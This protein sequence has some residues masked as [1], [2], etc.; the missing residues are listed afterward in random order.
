MGVVATHTK[1]RTNILR[2]VAFVDSPPRR[3][4]LSGH[5]MRGDEG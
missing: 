5:L 2:P 4:C 1:Q 3:V